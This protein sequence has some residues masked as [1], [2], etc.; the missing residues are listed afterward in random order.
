MFAAALRKGQR[1]VGEFHPIREFSRSLP[2][3]NEQ[4]RQLRPFAEALSRVKEDPHQRLYTKTRRFGWSR[5]KKTGVLG[6]GCVWISNLADLHFPKAL[7]IVD[8]YM[9]ANIAGC[10]RRSRSPRIIVRG[11]AA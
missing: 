6:D 3:V 8:L 2:A 7:K 11:D 10:C 9:R 5:A 4:T 1:E